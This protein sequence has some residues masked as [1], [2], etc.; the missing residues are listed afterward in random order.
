[1]SGIQIVSSIGT[2]LAVLTG[3]A[4]YLLQRRGESHKESTDAIAVQTGIATSAA[5]LA[6]R[7]QDEMGV[8]RKQVED[9]PQ[10][11]VDLAAAQEQIRSLQSELSLRTTRIEEL[12]R[13]LAAKTH[14]LA[15]MH[16]QYRML[17][18]RFTQEQTQNTALWAE[19]GRLRTNM[20]HVVLPGESATVV[21]P[22]AVVTTPVP[23]PARP[24][25]PRKRTQK[26]SPRN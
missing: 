16:D 15:S 8:L 1:M 11:R 19:I 9:V 18:Q 20:Q 2:L 17:E 3:F 14:E 13:Q 12:E 26:E 7:L 21:A 24:S 25:T 10:M 5:A 23:T 6:E 22:V 4:V